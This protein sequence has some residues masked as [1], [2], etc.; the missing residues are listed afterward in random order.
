LVSC[1]ENNIKRIR[2]E[3]YKVYHNSSR[4]RQINEYNAEL[5]ERRIEAEMKE[6][7]TE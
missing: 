5:N 3:K 1:N 4:F 7:M 2:N 6:M